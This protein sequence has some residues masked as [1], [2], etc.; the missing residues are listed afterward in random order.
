M[1]VAMAL[2]AL[3]SA[4]ETIRVFQTTAM[5]GRIRPEKRADA[6]TMP[7]LAVPANLHAITLP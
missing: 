4:K 2:R 5:A 1:V 6:R 3:T 7:M